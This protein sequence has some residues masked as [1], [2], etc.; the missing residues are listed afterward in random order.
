LYF[1]FF[2]SFFCTPF[3]SVGIAISISVHIFSFL[4]LIIISG[5]FAVNSLSVCTALL[6]LLLFALCW[7]DRKSHNGL[8]QDWQWRV[9]FSTEWPAE[10]IT[11][12]FL[13][14]VL[15]DEN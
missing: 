3:L 7:R 10:Y 6:L 1:N 15:R 12:Q 13:Q 4:F 9:R 14:D 2:S 8:S 11:L 5:L